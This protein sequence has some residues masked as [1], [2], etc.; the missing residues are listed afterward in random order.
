MS[1]NTAASDLAAQY[2]AQVSSDLE[3]NLKEQERIGTEIAVLQDQLTTLQRDHT[4]LVSMQQALGITPSP[5]QAP[6]PAR[7]A[8]TPTA[9]VPAPRKKTDS[10]AGNATRGKK[11][12]ATSGRAKA[13]KPATGTAGKA[14]VTAVKQAQPTL[15][16]LVRGHLGEQREP[17]SA[18]EIATALGQAHPERRIKATVVRTTLENLVAK[19]YAQRSKQGASVFY[20]AS[21]TPDQTSK[22]PSGKQSA[23]R[24]EAQP[25]HGA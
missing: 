18:A 21:D 7:P 24:P 11:A 17:R 13:G 1:E 16:D 2:A 23:D 9:A 15:I 4:V 25:D 19:G 22:D 6:Q 14:P 5:A 20:T 8:P 12:T 3:R 10:G